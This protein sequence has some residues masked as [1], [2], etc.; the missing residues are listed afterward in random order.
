M[1]RINKINGIM[2]RG[3]LILV[4]FL[5]LAG[6]GCV[7]TDDSPDTNNVNEAEWGC[8]EELSEN[9]FE[10]EL[11]ERLRSIRRETSD[12]MVNCARMN[13]RRK[14]NKLAKDVAVKRLP[15]LTALRDELA[16]AN[17]SKEKARGKK[18]HI[19]LLD[20]MIAEIKDEARDMP[21]L[22]L[23]PCTNSTGAAFMGFDFDS[24]IDWNSRTNCIMDSCEDGLFLSRELELKQPFHGFET[25][26]VRGD[27]DSRKAYAMVFDRDVVCEFDICGAQR[28]TDEVRR[29]FAESCGI[30][31][32]VESASDSW[33]MLKGETDA[34]RIWVC[35]GAYS[36]SSF[37]GDQVETESGVEYQLDVRRHRNG[38]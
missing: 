12:E 31:L 1:D 16:G 30:D 26:E 24:K 36:L 25:V 18:R 3:S 21:I 2:G 19:E 6:A 14:A 28:W 33:V 27:I 15:A 8:L 23:T 11:A 35:A 32:V 10:P 17:V 7:Y 34:L 13:D 20:Q 38:R 5:A 4:S 29:D 37:C 22:A 9:V